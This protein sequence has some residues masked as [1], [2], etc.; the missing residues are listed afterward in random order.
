MTKRPESDLWNEVTGMVG[1][2]VSHYRVLERIGQGGMGIVYKAE[3]TRLRRFVALK[4]L[5][6]AASGDPG[7]RS[8]FLREAQAAGSLD[9]PHICPVYGIEDC[10][11]GV[12]IVMA[13][14]DGWPLNRLVAHGLPLPRALDYALDIGAGLQEAH[15]HGIVHRDIKSANIIITT[16]GRAVITDFGL[17]MLSG[18]SRITRTG[19][20][21]GT[22]SYM[23]PEQALGQRVDPRTDIWSLGVVLHE[24]ITGKCPFGGN[25]MQSILNAILTEEPPPLHSAECEIPAELS[26]IVRKTLARDPDLRYQQVDGLLTAL[27]AVRHS[28][29]DA[30]GVSMAFPVSPASAVDPVTLLLP[31]DAA[32]PFDA[33]LAGAVSAGRPASARWRQAASVIAV[34][35]L[36]ALVVFWW[37]LAGHS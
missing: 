6:P 15:A 14:L 32:P 1:K 33:F 22:L 16:K 11:H 30:A 36:I 4:F 9:H 2:T 26:R 31:P 10:G 35:M 34:L 19:T 20:T 12:F 27:R 24:M 18:S 37:R 29:E 17:A 23:S 28:V 7:L 8:R 25:N 5:T 21:L 13:F 3:D